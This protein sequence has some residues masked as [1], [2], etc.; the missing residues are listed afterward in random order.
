[1]VVKCDAKVGRIHKLTLFTNNVQISV[2][3][4]NSVQVLAYDYNGAGFTS[5]SGLSFK[6]DFL[7]NDKLSLKFV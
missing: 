5:V 2:E 3:E 7:N 6:W 1:M 4:I